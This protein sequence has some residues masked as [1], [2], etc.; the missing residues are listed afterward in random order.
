MFE[1]WLVVAALDTKVYIWTLEFIIF[2]FLKNVD[3]GSSQSHAGDLNNCDEDADSEVA[4]L[5]DGHHICIVEIVQDWKAANS[6]DGIVSLSLM[7]L[8]LEMYSIVG[9]SWKHKSTTL[10]KSLKRH[11]ETLFPYLLTQQ[12][13]GNA[14]FFL[15]VWA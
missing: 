8:I 10:N 7:S 15:P 5:D 4:G 14:S 11:L 9:P 1:A 12:D 13:S 2:L 3:V 6:I